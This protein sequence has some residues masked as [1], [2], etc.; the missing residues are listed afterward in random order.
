MIL[1]EGQARL[2]NEETG[3]AYDLKAG[4]IVGLPQGLPVTWTLRGPF[5]KKF[6]VITRG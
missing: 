6:S 3:D 1:L 5:V 4:D 2:V